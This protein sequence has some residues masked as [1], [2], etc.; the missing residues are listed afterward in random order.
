[1]NEPQS[2]PGYRLLR[3]LGS[4]GMATV[5]LAH[6]D[7]VDREIALKLMSRH[8]LTDPRFAER[9]LREA[10]IAAKL[11]HRHI[12][13]IFDVGL[14]NEQ[15]FIAM[16][17]LAGGQVMPREGEPLSPDAALRC[18][19]EIALALDYAHSKGFIHRDVKPD[20]ILLREDGSCVLSDFGIARTVDSATMMTKTGA[21][22]GTPF[23]MSPEQLR[24]KEVDGRADLY[25]LGVV[26][27]QLL[28]GKVPY[29]ASDSLAIGI[30]HM[31]API[32]QLPMHLQYL[33]PLL[34]R[35]LQKEAS[36]RVQTGRELH[37]LVAKAIA[38]GARGADVIGA[39]RTLPQQAVQD[40]QAQV[41]PIRR[42]DGEVLRTRRIEPVMGESSR[43]IAQAGADRIEPNFGIK[44]APAKPKREIPNVKRVSPKPDSEQ[45]TDAGGRIEPSLGKI[46]PQGRAEPEFGR[47]DPAMAQAAW[48]RPE[49]KPE[50]SSNWPWVFGLLLALG[51]FAYYQRA[52]LASQWLV[53]KPNFSERAESSEILK[54]AV[55]AERLQRW[56]DDTDA[57]ALSLFE[58]A[59]Q[60]DSADASSQAGLKRVVSALLDEAQ[61]LLEINPTR[62]E[63]ILRRLARTQNDPRVGTLMSR[64]NPANN[65][66]VPTPTETPPT[67]APASNAAR[68]L[69]SVLEQALAAER[70]NQWL[71]TRGALALYLQALSL[72]PSSRRAKA[73]VKQA[74][75]A[76]SKL[77]DDA[78]R[79]D[80]LASIE[81]INKE[82]ESAQRDS[83]LRQL[84]MRQWRAAQTDAEE[85][86]GNI[87]QWLNDAEI[88]L[89]AGQLT[90]PQG[91]SAADRFAAVLVLDP[92]NTRAQAGMAKL[93][94][95]LLD[96]A[97]RAIA[98]EQLDMAA[99]L[100]E[101]ARE[102]GASIKALA[103]IELKLEKARGAESSEIVPVVVGNPAEDQAKQAELLAKID[104]AIAN[105]QLIDPPGDSALDL[106][107]QAQRLGP[108]PELTQRIQS[109][110]D[111]L[112]ANVGVMIETGDFETAA[113]ALSSLRALGPDPEASGLRA[114]LLAGLVAD[115]EAK[116]S[117][118]ELD[119]ASR[120]LALLKQL[121]A[122][123]PQLDALRL[124]L[125]NAGGGQ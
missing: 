42:H 49:R 78:I 54:Q 55:D 103:A 91:S 102:R 60:M 68:D 117:V 34:D 93:L 9:F 32:P 92:K 50:S 28:T 107:R 72:D 59:V 116:I 18:V 39:Q 122:R 11:Q 53:Y 12:V 83:S 80:E 26:F 7:S 14:A 61:G 17:Y 89:A 73:G 84:R 44:P 75:Q 110:R 1:M 69:D 64:L 94:A 5:Y 58:K 96:Q 115:I 15:P 37:V 13:S 112:K 97:E 100:I 67:T 20:N 90:S 51:L 98:T 121:D 104:Q 57:D 23:Y 95:A 33:Q 74:E 62:A 111:T 38:N 65:R 30:M 45:I 48:R 19:D 101:Q 24:G 4:G 113:N 81:R 71:G 43:D 87:A 88:A 124:A 36:D 27:Y 85:Q 105:N 16:E 35:M 41:S 22:V 63:A 108:S 70:S 25:S 79:R 40:A 106:I 120:R 10:R 29:T 123:H 31:T 21:I 3:L 2:I 119:A 77:L 118:G 52:W 109:L 46:N 56:F 76:A 86:R 125:V 47:M 114:Q 82:W 66:V 6:Q 99:R 8:L